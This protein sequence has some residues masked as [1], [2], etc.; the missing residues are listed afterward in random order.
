MDSQ[1]RRQIA[2]SLRAAAAKLMA[3]L[4]DPEERSS[5]VENEGPEAY[6]KAM[7][8]KFKKSV[9][10]NVNGYDLYIV[11]TQ[12]GRLIHIDGTKKAFRELEQATA[13]ANTLPKK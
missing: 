2:S 11:N 1:T 7:S 9:I 8:E 4:D 10:T 12:F 3:N 6:N 13:F 5:L